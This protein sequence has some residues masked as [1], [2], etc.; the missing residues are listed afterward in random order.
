M[1]QGKAPK[2]WELRFYGD[3]NKFRMYMKGNYVIRQMRFSGGSVMPNKWE[4]MVGDRVI[5]VCRS[6]ELA[7]FYAEQQMAKESE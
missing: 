7:R 5:A 2:G 1:K 3:D 4:V 6:R